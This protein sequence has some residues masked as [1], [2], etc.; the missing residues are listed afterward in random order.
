[1]LNALILGCLR[2][3][4]E[5]NPKKAQA[6]PIKPICFEVINV[7]INITLTK[8]GFTLLYR[9]HNATTHPRSSAIE[10]DMLNRPVSD[11]F[12]QSSRDKIK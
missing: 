7:E 10:T 4:R 11:G 12:A 9:N 8:I 2:T 5:A 3:T 6:A 1:M